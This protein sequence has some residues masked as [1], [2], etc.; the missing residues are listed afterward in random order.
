MTRIGA[1]DIGGTFTDVVVLN[2]DGSLGLDKISTSLPD[3]S[4]AAVQGLRNAAG[5]RLL[6]VTTVRH[7]T[8]AVV[9]AILERKGANVALV[10]T[11]GFRDVM[12]L[13]RGNRTRPY[14]LFY[15]HPTPLVPRHLRLELAERID[16]RGQVLKAIDLAEVQRLGEALRKLGV[17]AV[18]ISFLNSYINPAHEEEV[19]AILGRDL[20]GVFVT[21]GTELSREW[22]EYERTYTA[23]LNAYVGPMARRYLR[24]FASGLAQAGFTGEMLM[25]QSAGGVIS[26]AESETVPLLL[27]ESG[28]VAGI[29][30]ASE[31]ARAHGY[32]D[33]ISFDMGGTTAKAAIVEGGEPQIQTR[34][35]VGGYETGY[36]IQVSVV[37]VLEIG[38]G[39]GSIAWV[40]QEG[41]LQVGPRSAGSVPGPACYGTGGAELTVSD[42]D[43][44]L[45]RLDPTTFLGGRMQLHP[46]LSARV[47]RESVVSR[48][49]LSD[50]GLAS[51]VVKLANL[52]MSNALRRV[53]VER[54]YDPRDFA[55][56]AYGGGGPLH[57]VEVAREFGCA[58]V[59]IPPMPGHFSAWG[60]LRA[61]LRR[62][63]S[64]THVVQVGDDRHGE[65]R[66]DMQKLQDD[67]RAWREGLGRSVVSL[68]TAEARYLGQ[69]HTILVPLDEQ[70]LRAA[71]IGSRFTEI[72]LRRYGHISVGEPIEIVNLRLT[73]TTP[74]EA[75]VMPDLPEHPGVVPVRR[76]ARQVYF[77]ESGWVEAAVYVREQLPVGSSVHGPCIIEEPA[78]T[79]LLDRATRLTVLRDG[80]L[81][82]ELEELV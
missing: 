80:T 14:D 72:Y 31:L 60:M 58:K 61:P 37:D 13:G 74:G 75:G 47:A 22:R 28:P 76:T 52:A 79:T 49:G 21:T 34:Y 11:R 55:M 68:Y 65:I 19:K 53:T 44:L 41:G 5:G 9:N 66:Q 20:P 50:I 56:V 17:Q 78:S 57:A 51:G 64:R 62:D 27:L 38:T 67:S 63:F 32:N 23:A 7:G 8:T 48:L 29:I 30:A 18:A 12:E 25:M 26:M 16:G 82:L 54:G 1:I 40:D 43:L 71:T 10:T 6:S 4:V 81:L 2:P 33:L 36:P 42:S 24:G 39:G 69:E 59:L 45:G 35:Y 73:L 3:Q 70:D 46:E 15:R 77:E